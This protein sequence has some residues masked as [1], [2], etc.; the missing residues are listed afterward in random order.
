MAQ[1][2]GEPLLTITVEALENEHKQRPNMT[3]SL[4]DGRH[5][6]KMFN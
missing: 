3:Q 2:N 1:K 5:R 6:E 4:D